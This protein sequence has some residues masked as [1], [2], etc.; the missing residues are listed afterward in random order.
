M[1]P[2]SLDDPAI[3]TWFWPHKLPFLTPSCTRGLDGRGQN[4]PKSCIPIN[5]DVIWGVREFSWWFQGPWVTLPLLTD[6]DL[7]ISLFWPPCAHEGR[8]AG[9]KTALNNVFLLVLMC[10]EVLKSSHNG[11]L[12]QTDPAIVTWFWPKNHP[13]LRPPCSWL[14]HGDG[15]NCFKPAWY[16]SIEDACATGA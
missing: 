3:V 11:S 6:F 12:P 5:I 8:M 10:F 1:I 15:Q 9:A 7:K 14:K 2:G 16:M 4:G 13:F